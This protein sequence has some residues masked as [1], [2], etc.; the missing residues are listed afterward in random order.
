VIA[1]FHRRAATQGVVRLLDAA[2]LDPVACHDFPSGR[3]GCAVIQPAADAL[4][5][6][7]GGVGSST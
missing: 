3:P 2:G 7:L 1:T 5:E 6:S 4:G